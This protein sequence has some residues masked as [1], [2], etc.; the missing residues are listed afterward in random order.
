MRT[1]E[2]PSAPQKLEETMR[3]TVITKAMAAVVITMVGVMFSAIPRLP[4]QQ[5]KE[6]EALLGFDPIELIGG[7]ENSVARI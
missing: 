4:A 2:V 6:A 1:H 7:Q 3:K 5:L